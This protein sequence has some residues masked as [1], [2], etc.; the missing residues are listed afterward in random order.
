[1]KAEINIIKKQWR[2]ILMRMM[3][4]RNSRDYIRKYVQSS[5]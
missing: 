4:K 5:Y 1:M 2:L 3:K